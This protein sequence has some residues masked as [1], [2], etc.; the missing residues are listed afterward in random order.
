MTAHQLETIEP[1]YPSRHIA[2]NGSNFLDSQF[3]GNELE[4]RGLAVA[5]AK[6]KL[7]ILT[8]TQNILLGKLAREIKKNL[9][10]KTITEARSMAMEME[11]WSLH[12]D[13]RI[14]AEHEYDCAKYRY[15]AFEAWWQ[16]ERTN[17]SMHRALT[18]M[19]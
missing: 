9:G 19:R 18:Q 6:R 13:G 17:A 7:N 14:A 3:I 12:E 11:E 4:A 5:D 8:K 15:T 16:A 2:N 1:T 10:I